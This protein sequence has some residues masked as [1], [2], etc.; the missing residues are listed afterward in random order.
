[1]LSIFL[2]IAM[3]VFATLVFYAESPVNPIEHNSDFNTIPI[4]FWW[5]IITMTTVGYGDVYPES[6]LGR[7]IGV[8]CAVS[9]VLL[10]ALTIPVISN[11]FS[12]FYLHGRT[13]Q[14]MTSKKRGQLLADGMRPEEPTRKMAANGKETLRSGMVTPLLADSNSEESGIL[15]ASRTQEEALGD[16]SEHADDDGDESET[17]V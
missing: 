4:G 3:L 2:V 14:E 5:A 7:S 9:G 17:N 1:M 11:N 15:V 13:R 6:G 8:L 12:L 10:I 16:P